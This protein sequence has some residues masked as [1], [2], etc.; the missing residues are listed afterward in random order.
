MTKESRDNIT[1]PAEMDRFIG[2]LLRHPEIENLNIRNRNELATLC[3]EIYWTKFQQLEA[4]RI[5]IKTGKV[6]ATIKGTLTKKVNKAAKHPISK[7]GLWLPRKTNILGEML[8]CL[9]VQYVP[10]FKQYSDLL[11]ITAD[12]F[13]EATERRR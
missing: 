3:Y 4:K 6:N 13:R 1:L 11:K 9:F 8:R 12:D 5:D 7:S 10:E 2:L